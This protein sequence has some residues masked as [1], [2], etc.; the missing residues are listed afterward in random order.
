[1]FTNCGHVI[2]SLAF[3]RTEM[4]SGRRSPI[5][6]ERSCATPSR[7]NLTSETSQ[8]SWEARRALRSESSTLSQKHQ[9][10]LM[11]RSKRKSKPLSYSEVTI[12]RKQQV[13]PVLRAL[14]RSLQ[15]SHYLRG[16]FCGR[17]DNEPSAGAGQA[18]YEAPQPQSYCVNCIVSR[19]PRRRTEA[20]IT[21]ERQL[22]KGTRRTLG[23]IHKAKGLEFPNVLIWN[24]SNADFPITDQLPMRLRVWHM[25]A[26]S[27]AT[28]SLTF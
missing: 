26:I 2:F 28:E 18:I 25:F 5:Q 10:D 12:G 1:M 22:E 23:T 19:G 11:L 7:G 6:D 13:G 15:Y 4:A 21:H 9:S 24:F 16:V 20:A 14:S 3:Y 17:N 8:R 27:R